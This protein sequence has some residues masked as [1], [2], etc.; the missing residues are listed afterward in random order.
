MHGVRPVAGLKKALPL[1]AMFFA[2]H[3]AASAEEIDDMDGYLLSV[4]RNILGNIE[5]NLLES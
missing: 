3:G 1:D 2:L 5:E 4:V